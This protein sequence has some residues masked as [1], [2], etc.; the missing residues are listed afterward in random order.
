MLRDDVRTICSCFGNHN[1]YT[2]GYGETGQAEAATHE[3]I[4]LPIHEVGP[5]PHGRV[6]CYAG[7][8]ERHRQDEP[9]SYNQN[10]NCADLEELE[11]KYDVMIEVKMKTGRMPL[12]HPARSCVNGHLF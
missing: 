9:N 2:C 5:C 10:R 11:G 12:Q 7:R 1:G 3:V 4:S 8:G 6:E